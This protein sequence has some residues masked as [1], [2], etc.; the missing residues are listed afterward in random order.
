[1]LVV[2]VTENEASMS[3]LAKE[4]MA[5]MPEIKG[6]VQNINPMPGNVV[7][8]REFRTLAGQGW[9][10]ERLSGL[11]FKVSPASFFQVNPAQAEKLYAKVLEFAQL[12]GEE[13]V[14][15]AY[16]GVGTLT[17]ILA[18]HAKEVIGVECVADAIS[19]AQENAAR[20][21]ISNVKFTC[22]QAEE[23]IS[24]LKEVDVAVLNPPR[25]GCARFFLEKLAQ[26]GP[27]RI[28]YVSCDPATLARDLQFLCGKG[29]RLDAVQPYDMFPQTAHVE[30]VAVLFGVR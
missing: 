8:S 27:K 25:K 1:V 14:L 28:V 6:V 20:N 15:D 22:G 21:Q 18:Q 29:Y 13:S 30:C 23:L 19:D 5:A 2:L 7:L 11:M 12:S 9:I 10:E 3:E 24:N 16:C 26:H 17:L 4:L